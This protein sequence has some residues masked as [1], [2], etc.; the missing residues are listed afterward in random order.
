MIRA[1]ALRMNGNDIKARMHEEHAQYNYG[2]GMKMKDLFRRS[3]KQV[4]VQAEPVPDPNINRP[5]AEK[6]KTALYSPCHMHPMV[7]ASRS[8]TLTEK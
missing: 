5:D 8:S 4:P 6:A 1:A 7:R 2:F 3:K